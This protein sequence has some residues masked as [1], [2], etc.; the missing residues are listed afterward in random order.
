MKIAYLFHGHSRTWE[1]CYKNFF[2]NIYS[3]LPGDIFIQTW[4][5]V[6]SPVGSWWNG[7]N[8]L[9]SGD[10]R[11]ISAQ[12]IDINK[13]YQIYKPKSLIIDHD[14]GILNIR[15]QYTNNIPDCRLGAKNMLFGALNIFNIAKSYDKYDIYFSTRLDI[16][17]LTQL[18]LDEL[19]ILGEKMLVSETRWEIN[20]ADR[21]V[22]DI[23][24]IGNEEQFNKKTKFY[25]EID[26]Y[27]YNMNINFM[28]YTYE[29]GL[30]NY[31]DD[32]GLTTQSSKIKYCAP[33]INGDITF[34]VDYNIP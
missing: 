16:L 15:N 25:Y 10:M 12:N 34:W 31:Y 6:N 33:R 20:E 22:F 1:I 21:M 28:E 19:S 11:T 3:I 13:I 17:F 27:W 24:S 26:K 2:H 29:H 18:Q 5:T 9:L 14:Y 32:I 30:K 8:S 7:N 23:W 4:N